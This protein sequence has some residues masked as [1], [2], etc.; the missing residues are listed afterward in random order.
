MDEEVEVV[1]EVEEVKELV[2]VG[3]GGGRMTAHS[4]NG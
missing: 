2:G 1:M 4:E 3:E